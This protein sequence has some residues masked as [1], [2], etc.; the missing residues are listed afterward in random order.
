M[1]WTSAQPILDVENACFELEVI[2]SEGPAT[3]SLES[4]AGLIIQTK[5]GYVRA[6][7]AMVGKHSNY[8]GIDTIASHKW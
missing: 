2:L 5:A 7:S 8:Q 3:V 1:K 6:H 4:N